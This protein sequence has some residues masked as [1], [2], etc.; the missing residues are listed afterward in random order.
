MRQY[1]FECWI[2]GN[3]TLNQIQE[4]SG[5]LKSTILYWRKAYNWDD[6]RAALARK[7]NERYEITETTLVNEHRPQIANRQLQSVARADELVERE[8]TRHLETEG[9]DPMKPADI[10]RLM[11]VSADVGQKLTGGKAGNQPAGH[12][13]T[14]ISRSVVCVGLKPLGKTMP[15][16]IEAVSRVTEEIEPL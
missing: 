2:S 12:G 1:V 13:N 6:R 11:K 16:A 3:Y 4:L 14:F 10:A 8:L 15:K 9:P 7:L 5:V